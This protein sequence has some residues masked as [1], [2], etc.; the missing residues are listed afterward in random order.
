MKSWM[1]GGHS[2]QPGRRLSRY[3]CATQS[4]VRPAGQQQPRQ[5]ALTGL[6]TQQACKWAHPSGI[7]YLVTTSSACTTEKEPS[8]A[9]D[10]QA[11][12]PL[13]LFARLHWPIVRFWVRPGIIY[14]NRAYHQQLWRV[15]LKPAFSVSDLW[16]VPGGFEGDK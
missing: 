16:R 1:R 3:A 10:K 13:L 6:L 5:K 2:K 15:T 4:F 7:C 11:C 14:K 8:A 12:G 9:R